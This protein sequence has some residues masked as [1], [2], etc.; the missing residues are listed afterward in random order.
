LRSGDWLRFLKPK[1]SSIGH[2]GKSKTVNLRYFPSL[3]GHYKQEDWQPSI[4]IGTS[5]GDINLVVTSYARMTLQTEQSICNWLANNLKEAAEEDVLLAFQRLMVEGK[6]IND[7]EIS[8][9]I[10]EI[11]LSKEK[12]AQ[13]DFLR[14][15]DQ[16]CH[17]V[18]TVWLV[19]GKPSL[20]SQLIDAIG[21]IGDSKEQIYAKLPRRLH[22]L[23][24]LYIQDVYY[25][26][27]LKLQIVVTRQSTSTNSQAPLAHL[28][29]RYPFLYESSL[30]AEDATVEY[31]EIIQKTKRRAQRD[32]EFKLSKYLTFQIRKASLRQNPDPQKSIDPV[33]NPSLLKSRDLGSA[34]Q[35]FVSNSRH[36]NENPWDSA[37]NF[38]AQIHSDLNFVDFKELLYKYLITDFDPTNQ[39]QNSFKAKLKEYLRGVIPENHP[40]PLD[41]LSQVRTYTQL[42]NFLVIDSAE[43][44]NHMV[45]INLVSNIGSTATVSLILKIILI[46]PKAQTS[47]NHRLAILFNHYYASSQND[48]TWLIKLLENWHIASTIHFGKI[49]TSL[50]KQILAKKS[51]SKTSVS[52]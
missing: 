25:Q 32:Y 17:Q 51:N 19:D 8:M 1:L 52:V 12:S 13:R 50:L 2:F 34:L 29:D 31:L 33:V 3:G 41:E 9:A 14:I 48:V 38:Q 15:L 43:R 11:A 5:L 40:K 42:L 4:L 45:L 27:L 20:I 24:K 44:P 23:W 39:A 21:K 46:C 6:G 16:V 37:C 22:Q 47:L 10:E 36:G 7:P 30:L 49:D 35:T 26:R 28:L 18:I